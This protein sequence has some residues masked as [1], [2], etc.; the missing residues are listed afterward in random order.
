MALKFGTS[1]W[2]AILADEFT[3][4]NARRVVAS[5]ADTVLAKGGAER[6]IVVGS[7]TRFLGERFRAEASALL[8]SRGIPVFQTTRDIPTPVLSFE[9]RRLGAAGGINFTASH[10][11][12]EY[13]GLKFSTADGAPALPDVT[14]EIERNLENHAPGSVTIGPAKA[15][16]R[17]TDPTGPYLAAILARVDVEAIRHARLRVAVDT[18]Y[19][20]SRGYLDA[21][22]RL[23]GCDVTAFHAVADPTF[24]GTSP[25]CDGP[26]LVEMRQ[27]I[28]R[29]KLTLGLA[30]DGDAD[31]FAVVDPSGR[32]V[33][34][35]LVLALL[36]E[37]RAASAPAGTGIG[38]SVATT[39]L[40][41]DVAKAAGRP[42]FETPVGFKFL[43]E[44][45]L[46]NKIFLGGE[47]S[48]GLTIDGHVP[49]KDGILAGLLVAELVAKTGKSPD[50][51][52]RQLFARTGVRLT[53]RLDLRLSPEL[54]ERVRARVANPPSD[55]GGR[56][57]D[58][59]VTID[60]VK[61]IL[62]DDSWALV[63]LSGTEPV[64]R[65]YVEA[66]SP[67]ALASLARDA[68]RW[69]LG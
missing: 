49:E 27:H 15:E 39:H 41:D 53:R 4:D 19:G 18:R 45:L 11:P 5:I 40:L 6:G 67:K 36:A 59:I 21:A 26:N 48:A 29:E 28:R 30:T 34:P 43:G 66:R 24:G 60:G 56:K 54:M 35:N 8:A 16:I 63:R 47:E 37:S 22:L 42:L 33:T 32:Y 25:Q 52:L 51:L 61:A 68:R 50:A 44:L 23:A 62:G 64:A 17:P 7:D 20:T 69:L 65:L 12:P 13:Q 57:V 58:R 55:I 9:I 2:R 10:N 38:R 46:A 3:F 1:G 31:R 14:K